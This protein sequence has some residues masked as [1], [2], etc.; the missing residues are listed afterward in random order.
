MNTPTH[1]HAGIMIFTPDYAQQLLN[2]NT[3][4]RPLSRTKVNEWAKQLKNGHWLYNGDT[5]RIDTKGRLLDGQH[6]LHACVKTGVPFKAILATGI[7]PDAFHTI[8]TGKKRGPVDTLSISGEKNTAVL[9]SALLSLHKYENGHFKSHISSRGFSGL[10]ND[11]YLVLLENNPGMRDSAN[12][13]STQ[14]K[15][16]NRSIFATFHF[17]ATIINKAKADDFCEQVFTGIGLDTASPTL[18]LRN[19]LLTMFMNPDSPLPRTVF[20][21]T[22]KGFNA[23]MKNSKIKRLH[24]RICGENPEAFPEFKVK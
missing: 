22:I 11:D 17:L 21:L 14:S 20:A 23:Y 12:Y 19:T 8:D 7:N 2:Y 6:R 10:T 3:H 5:I 15:P 9:A 4:N 16:F 1:E 13:V 18:V 24:F